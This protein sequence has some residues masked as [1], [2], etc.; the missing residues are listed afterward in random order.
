MPKWTIEIA[1]HD[2]ANQGRVTVE[3]DSLENACEEAIRLSNAGEVDIHL[4]TYD[5]DPTYVLAAC[6]GDGDPWSSGISI[7]HRFSRL[8]ATGGI[9]P[10]QFRIAADSLAGALMSL[11]DLTMGYRWEELELGW[12]PEALRF[13]RRNDFDLAGLDCVEYRAAAPDVFAADYLVADRAGQAKAVGSVEDDGNSVNTEM[14]K[15]IRAINAGYRNGH[16]I[17]DNEMIPHMETLLGRFPEHLQAIIEASAQG[18]E[19]SLT[20]LL[21]FNEARMTPLQKRIRDF[22]HE[23]LSKEGEIEIDAGAMLSV[24]DDAEIA[25]NDG[26]YVMAWRWV[27]TKDVPDE[28]LET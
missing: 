3:A 17:Y 16:T 18:D 19:P 22:A 14:V 9:D 7:A 5:P 11:R 1:W 21:A 25:E 4:H 12:L 2:S 26:A 23:K 20:A 24:Q 8:A 6:E 13:G 27:Y 10:S 28:A 15:A